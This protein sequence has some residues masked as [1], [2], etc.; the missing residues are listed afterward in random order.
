[1]LGT[2]ICLAACGDTY[3]AKIGTPE[4]HAVPELAPDH[5]GLKPVRILQSP[6]RRVRL[7]PVQGWQLYEFELEMGDSYFNYIRPPRTES[8]LTAILLDPDRK[9]QCQI[10]LEMDRSAPGDYA[11]NLDDR[12]DHLNY[13]ELRTVM[14]SIP[15]GFVADM[16]PHPMDAETPAPIYEAQWYYHIWEKD[17]PALGF[18]VADTMRQTSTHAFCYW[19]NGERGDNEIELLS[20]I[21]ASVRFLG[22][23]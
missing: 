9:A 21:R 10:V 2:L 15:Y 23:D 4:D 11:R 7:I 17:Y 14:S 8:L 18:G 5:L 1:M 13:L 19:L 6:D 3:N 20:E 16:W 12:D 22:A